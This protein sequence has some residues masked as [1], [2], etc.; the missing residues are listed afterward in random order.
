MTHKML[1][2]SLFVLSLSGLTSIQAQNLYIKPKDNAQLFIELNN[3]QKLTFSQGKVVAHKYNSGIDTFNLNELRFLSFQN[4][5][6]AIDER[7]TKTANNYFSAYPVPANDWLYVD[8]RKNEN[9]NGFISILSL[10]G[11]IL[12]TSNSNSEVIVKLNISNLPTG[13]YICQFS[14]NLEIQTIK[15]IKL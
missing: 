1:K 12:K 5:L 8:L 13:V 4:Y 2:I 10:D 9:P 15:F 11:K 14:N 3:I 7:K 6:T